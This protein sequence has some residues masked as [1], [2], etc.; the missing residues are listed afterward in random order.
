MK[1]LTKT[2]NILEAKHGDFILSRNIDKNID[3][4]NIIKQTMRPIVPKE[5]QLEIKLSDNTNI[6]TSTI[7]PTLVN[8]NNTWLYVDAKDLIVGDICQSLSDATTTIIS[9]ENTYIDENFADFSIDVVENYYAGKSSNKM[10]VVH[11]SA[12][13]YYPL[14]H[15]EVEDMLVLKNNKGVED[16]RV[17]H[18]DYGVQFNKLM[19]ERLLTGGDIT[20]F[21]PSDVP[22]LY[23][24]FFNDQDTFKELYE[25]AERKTKVRKKTVK[26]MDLFN[27]F[28]SERKD[29]GRIYLMNV[30]H[31][32]THGSFVES[33]AP[34]RMSNL[35]VTG[36]TT[37]DIS[38]NGEEMSVNI[39]EL[40][41]L[42]ILHDDV[43]VRSYSQE[44][45]K[46][47]YKKIEAFAK[48]HPEAE[49]LEIT[50]TES[51]ATIRCTPEHLVYTTNRGY[52]RAADLTE[53]DS[54][55][56]RK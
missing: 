54:L 40:G 31:A 43:M 12:T 1:L 15:L 7:H 10:M 14:W 27:S 44:N 19:Y 56:I 38:V 42:M 49:V 35:C 22:G 20:L 8:R 17:R 5:N 16:N 32:N 9:I 26:A 39:D 25:A 34:I 48:T 2:I 50:D 21:S 24:A 4:F 30:D 29:T 55:M 23:E 28:L 6:H 45:D 11:N 51:G 46:Q 41:S 18:M 36:D 53:I 47:E 52:V 3:E 37:V 13:L 33:L